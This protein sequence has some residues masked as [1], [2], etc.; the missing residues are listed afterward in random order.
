[1]TK[2]DFAPLRQTRFAG[3]PIDLE[4]ELRR[5]LAIKVRK[6]FPVEHWSRQSE[7]KLEKF[8]KAAAR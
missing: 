7:R 6:T 8:R 3:V 2:L 1:M 4:P 5:R